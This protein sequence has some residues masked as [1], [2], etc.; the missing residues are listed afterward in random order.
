MSEENPYAPPKGELKGPVK[1]SAEDLLNR[2]VGALYAQTV[3]FTLFGILLV[4]LTGSLSSSRLLG[5]GL[6]MLGCG[7]VSYVLAW[8]ARVRLETSG[9]GNEAIIW[10][11]FKRGILSKLLGLI[12][13]VVF[14]VMIVL[15]FR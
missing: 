1:E 2:R 12:S 13:A 14:G 9:Q 5:S 3:L 6:V 4:A 8:K 15:V 11:G 10:S 7:I